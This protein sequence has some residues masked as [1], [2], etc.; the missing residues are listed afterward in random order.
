MSDRNEWDAVERKLHA[1]STAR[2][3]SLKI[4]KPVV[5]IEWYE[6]DGIATV[7]VGRCKGMEEIVLTASAQAEHAAEAISAALEKA[8]LALE[9]T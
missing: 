9:K 1:L 5:R 2:G 6:H 4:Y 8:L 7:E 3:G